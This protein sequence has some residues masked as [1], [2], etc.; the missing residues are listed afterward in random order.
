MPGTEPALGDAVVEAGMLPLS[1]T[2]RKQKVLCIIFLNEKL[3]LRNEN[4]C[5]MFFAS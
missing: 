4:M 5:M 3:D 2:C 1:K